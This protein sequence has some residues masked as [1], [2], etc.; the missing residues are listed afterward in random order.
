MVTV[1]SLISD[2]AA[3][4]P[5]SSPATTFHFPSRALAALSRSS[6]SAAPTNRPTTRNST[7][8][9]SIFRLLFQEGTPD[10]NRQERGGKRYAAFL[11][12]WGRH[13]ACLGLAGKM[14]APRTDGKNPSSRCEE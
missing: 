5:P 8:F 3:F 13:L 7:P 2:A 10:V 9:A 14:P 6:L 12:P 1:A 11:L 4:L